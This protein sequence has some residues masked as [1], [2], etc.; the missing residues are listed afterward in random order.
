MS[1]QVEVDEYGNYEKALGA[2]N[3]ASRCIAK[4]ADQYSQVAE[5]VSNKIALVKKFLDVRR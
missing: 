1:H 3:E 4:D 2:L 5:A